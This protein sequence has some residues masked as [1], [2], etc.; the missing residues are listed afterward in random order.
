MVVGV[1]YPLTQSVFDLCRRAEDFTPPSKDHIR[2]PDKQDGSSSD[3]IQWGGAEHF[4]SML[5]SDIIPD[6]ESRL[7]PQLSIVPSQRALF[8]HSFGGLFSL[9]A[10]FTHRTLFNTYLIASPS[11]WFNNC[12]IIREQEAEYLAG[13]QWNVSDCH[14]PRLLLTYGSLEQFPQKKRNET[15]EEFQR[16]ESGAAAKRMRDNV[17]E[18]QARLSTSGRLGQV[19]IQELDGED[20]GRAAGCAIQR[21]IQWLLDD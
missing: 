8:G 15:D 6:I 12:A 16:R 1:G 5:E 7:L 10:L 3:D 18:M 19:E 9:F 14:K 13:Y 21:G 20:H 4:L 17:H 2:G 11:I